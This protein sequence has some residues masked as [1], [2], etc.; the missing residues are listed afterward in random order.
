MAK[1]L[2]IGYGNTLRGDDGIGRLAAERLRESAPGP[3][4]EVLAV[5]QLTPELA[6]PVSRADFVVFLDAREGGMP[7]TVQRE[8]V[9]PEPGGEGAFTHQASPSGLLAA[10]SLLYGSRPEGVLLSASGE[11]FAYGA[12]LSAAAQAAEA[13]LVAIC[14]DL[15]RPALR[16]SRDDVGEREREAAG[17]SSP[18]RFPTGPH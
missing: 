5:H 12:G 1:V 10:A 11:S 17:A 3:D 15:T 14:K 9:H 7:G 2:I 4:I 6:E 8:P 16:R 13:E 18:G